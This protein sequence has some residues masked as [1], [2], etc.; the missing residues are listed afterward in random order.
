[1]PVKKGAHSYI[2]ASIVNGERREIYNINDVQVNIGKFSSIAAGCEVF[3]G[4]HPSI[5]YP[6]CVASY[7]FDMVVWKVDW[8]EVPRP[9]SINI[10][11]D[12]WIGR[13]V[14]L[15]PGITIG[16]GAIIGARSVVTKDVKPY[17]MVAGN[18]ARHVRFRFTEEQ[19]KRLLEIKWWDWPTDI[20]RGNINL[21]KDIDK[22]L[23]QSD[24]LKEFIK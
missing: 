9:A 3:G 24:K 2:V 6:K 4:N 1:M 5:A 18:P 16:D 12:V 19:I 10:G 22:L 23:A 20:L 17:E 7:P 15:K 14:S 13:D 11:N 21:L 8:P